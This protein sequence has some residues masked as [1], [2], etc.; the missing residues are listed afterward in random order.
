ME[1]RGG[2]IKQLL[3]RF[4]YCRLQPGDVTT[5]LVDHANAVSGRDEEATRMFEEEPGKAA[6][7]ITIYILDVVHVHI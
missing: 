4:D 6:S 3:T 7:S 5:F 1:H 2:K